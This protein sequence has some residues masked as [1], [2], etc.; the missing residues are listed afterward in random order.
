MAHSSHICWGGCSWPVD[1]AVDFDVSLSKVVVIV[2]FTTK[3][4]QSNT[5]AYS[6]EICWEFWSWPFDDFLLILRSVGQG[7]RSILPWK[8]MLVQSISRERLSLQ[9]SEFVKSDLHHQKLVISIIRERF[10]AQIPLLILRSSGQG[11]FDIDDKKYVWPMT[12]ERFV[13][14]ALDLVES[15]V[16]SCRWPQ[17]ILK[18]IWLRWPW[19]QKDCLIKLAYNSPI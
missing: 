15:L 16:M 7:S 2:T 5:L 8:Q 6:P 13:L 12:I 19:S 11:Y 1:D 3:I 10:G 17:L 14:Q 9:S 4:F 18:S